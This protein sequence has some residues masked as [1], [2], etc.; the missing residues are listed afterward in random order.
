MNVSAYGPFSY[1]NPGQALQTLNGVGVTVNPSIGPAYS[2][3]LQTAPSVASA[4]PASLL[5]P[6]VNVGGIA[7]TPFELLTYYILYR[8]VR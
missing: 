6:L 5:T 7:L 4:I 2:L 3:L 1:A 8:I